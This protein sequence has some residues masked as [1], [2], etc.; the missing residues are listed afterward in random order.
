[1]EINEQYGEKGIQGCNNRHIEEK[2]LETVFITAWNTLL[3]NRDK[4]KEKWRKQLTDKNPL[5][6]YRAKDF[7][8]LAEK[9]EHIEKL[10]LTC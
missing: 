4:I 8:K 9:T 1:M 5:T 2:N 7:M 3:D 6:A 10:D